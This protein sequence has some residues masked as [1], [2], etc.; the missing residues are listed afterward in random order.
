MRR[1][2]SGGGG[3]GTS[4]HRHDASCPGGSAACAR[5]R[6]AEPRCLLAFRERLDRASVEDASLDRAPLEHRPLGGIELVEPGGESAW[7]VG[8]TTTSPSLASRT[9][10]T[11]SSRKSGF[12]S[13]AA[14][15][16]SR[17]SPRR[18][19]ARP[20]AVRSP[21]H[22][23]AR[24]A[25]SW[26]STCLRPSPAALEQLG[27]AMQSRS[28]GASRAEVGDVLHEVEEPSPRPSAGRR[29]RR[30]AAALA[31]APRAACGTPRRS[32]RPRSAH[33]TRRGA[34]GAARRRRPRGGAEL[35]DDLDHRP[36]RDPL[37][38]RETAPV[39]DAGL[40]LGEELRG[41]PRLADPGDP[42]TVKSWH[43]RS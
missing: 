38:V 5:A 31:P 7:M 39:H 17:S 16:R 42:R 12:P 36:V 10:A 24:A 37:A 9:S 21:R 15:I 18:R 32:R 2:G 14:E 34:T 6:R 40:D 27:R 1:R 26:R 30:R 8:G 43:E 23:A 22:R 4:R 29:A 35:L 3:S 25:R 41:E 20:G 11:I 28:I 19:R 13:A 33:P